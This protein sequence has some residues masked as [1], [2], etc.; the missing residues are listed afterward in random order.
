MKRNNSLQMLQVQLNIKNKIQIT[1][2]IKIKPLKHIII[3]KTLENN[4]NKDNINNHRV[5]NK[6]KDRNLNHKTNRKLKNQ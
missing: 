6:E 5:R 2:I 3:L 4:N 1:K